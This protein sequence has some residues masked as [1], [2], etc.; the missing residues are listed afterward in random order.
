MVDVAR[1]VLKSGQYTSKPWCIE[2][3]WLVPF[4][5]SLRGGC[6]KLMVSWRQTNTIARARTCHTCNWTFYN[7][8]KP[9]LIFISDN[10]ISRG[11]MICLLASISWQHLCQGRG[12]RPLEERSRPSS[13]TS[14]GLGARLR[15][16]TPPGRWQ[17]PG[18]TRPWWPQ[19]TRESRGTGS[20]RRRGAASLPGRPA[21]VR[22]A[23]GRA[24]SPSRPFPRSQTPWRPPAFA[25]FYP[26][27]VSGTDFCWPDGQENID[28]L[29]MWLPP[30][31]EGGR[32]GCR[33][34]PCPHPA[35]LASPSK[36]ILTRKTLL[37][38]LMLF[39]CRTCH[40]AEVNEGE[41]KAPQG[42]VQGAG[43]TKTPRTERVE[44]VKQFSFAIQDVI[45]HQ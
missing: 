19:T 25:P 37:S 27:R 14:V 8:S 20:R 32:A 34:P 4:N 33:P 24:S 3:N 43:H 44:M 29:K 13:G 2:M 21:S 11:S 10:A 26:P 30:P 22:R 15:W 1:A 42:S 40:P 9:P 41:Q 23:P 5:R 6:K 38:S 36:P 45:V 17:T 18:N 7:F 35:S 39:L 16:S 28:G 31:W 12:Q